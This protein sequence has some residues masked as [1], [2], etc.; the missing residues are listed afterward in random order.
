MHS[1]VT[2]II[3]I[4]LKV[5]RGDRYWRFDAAIS[6]SCPFGKGR[7]DLNRVRWKVSNIVR[8]YSVFIFHVIKAAAA[9]VVSV[10][11]YLLWC[12]IPY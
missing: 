12:N 1:T 9:V 6:R 7:D 8:N 3:R 10:S 2:S 4:R 11:L 5:S